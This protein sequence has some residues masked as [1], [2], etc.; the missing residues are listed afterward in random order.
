MTKLV[1]SGEV[2]RMLGVSRATVYR[3]RKERGLPC[4][5]ICERTFRYDVDKVQEWVARQHLD[6]SIAG[7]S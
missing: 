7:K 2:A 5:R 6:S 3:M 4:T 1:S